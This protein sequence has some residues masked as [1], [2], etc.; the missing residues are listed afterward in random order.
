MWLVNC[1]ND[2]DK[3]RILNLMF[4]NFSDYEVHTISE[5]LLFEY[6]N[7]DLVESFIDQLTDLEKSCILQSYLKMCKD[8]DI[9]PRVEVLYKFLIKNTKILKYS[10]GVDSEYDI[11]K[12]LEFSLLVMKYLNS[13]KEFITLNS[14]SEIIS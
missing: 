8:K 10:N 4:N 1:V 7:N 5:L 9:M 11:E 3:I 13:N 2:E 12:T 6:N 14:I